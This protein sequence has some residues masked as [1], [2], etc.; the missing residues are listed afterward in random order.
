[1]LL[2]AASLSSTTGKGLSPELILVGA[3]KASSAKTLA[4]RD[5]D[6]NHKTQGTPRRTPPKPSHQAS[7]KPRNGKIA[8]EAAKRAKE[9]RAALFK[10]W[11]S[12]RELLESANSPEERYLLTNRYLTE[13]TV[14]KDISAVVNDVE[15]FKLSALVEIWI[16]YC[17]RS[18]KAEGMHIAALI[19]DSLMGLSRSTTELLGSVLIS[20]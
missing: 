15:L 18:K 6:V 14:R 16:N 7:G 9:A 4:V 11:R 20:C 12:A 17:Q 2:Y 19:H 1:M 13:A 3:S 8:V 10:S 5:Q